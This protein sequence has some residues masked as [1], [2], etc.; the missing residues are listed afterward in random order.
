[1]IDYGC[2]SG[3]LAI[4]ACKLG[5]GEVTGVDIDPQAINR[6]KKVI[7]DAGM[8]KM[9]FLGLKTLTIIKNAIA[10]VQKNRGVDI[11]IDTIDMEDSKTFELYQKAETIEGGLRPIGA[12][13]PAGRRPLTTAGHKNLRPGGKLES[14]IIEDRTRRAQNTRLKPSYSND[15]PVAESEQ[16][17]G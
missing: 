10:L 7:E 13:A 11:D 4:A 5:A 16:V 8:L 9:D 17:A 14:E 1:V 12:Y 15:I 3:I 6:S 2:G